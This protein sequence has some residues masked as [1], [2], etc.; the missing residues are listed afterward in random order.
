MRP[1]CECVWACVC[2]DFS[3]NLFAVH[4]EGSLS[5]LWKLFSVVWKVKIVAFLPSKLIQL[6][7]YELNLNMITQVHLETRECQY[8]TLTMHLFFRTPCLPKIFQPSVLHQGRFLNLTIPAT[9]R[10]ERRLKAKCLFLLC[11][12]Q[13]IKVQKDIIWQWPGDPLLP[14]SVLSFS[15]AGMLMVA[16]WWVQLSCVTDRLT[17]S[18]QRLFMEK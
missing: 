8:H 7:Q 15:Q 1:L 5:P 11:C 13:H 12:S 17:G 4:L 9:F 10:N 16:L 6:S 18:S 2:V 14:L 3:V